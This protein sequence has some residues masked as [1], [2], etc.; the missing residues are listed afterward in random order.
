MLKSFVAVALLVAGTAAT[1]ATPINERHPLNAG[2][3]LSVKN[4]AGSI[5]VKAWDRNEVQLSGWLGEDVEKLEVSGDAASLAIEVRYPRKMRGG[6]EDTALQLQVPAG[7][8]LDLEAVSADVRVSGMRGP[9]KASSVSGDV[10]LDVGSS[11]V[12]ANSVS[13]NVKLRAP[14]T[15]TRLASVSGDL[16]ADGLRGTLKAETVSGEVEISGGPYAELSAESV[17]GDLVLGVEVSDGANLSAE[18]LSGDIVLRLPK[19]PNAK[20]TMKTFSGELRNGFGP[21]VDEDRRSYA[22]SYGGG[23][24]VIRLNSFSGDIDIGDGK[25]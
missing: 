13:G 7:V 20:L 2:G 17:S 16:H 22:H 3:R 5:E 10:S 1:A 12:E 18:T 11:K 25:R 15:E 4:L 6:L 9:I 24:G 23:K 19:S 14:A 8:V 21:A